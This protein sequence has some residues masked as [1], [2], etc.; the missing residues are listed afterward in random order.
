LSLPEYDRSP[1]DEASIS[2]ARAKLRRDITQWRAYQI[3][4]FPKIRDHIPITDSTRPED[5]NL[6]LP[7]A[8]S[9]ALRIDLGLGDVAAIEYDLREGQAHDALHAVREAIKTFNYNISFKKTNIHGQ[10]A[11]TRAQAFLQS[12]TRDKVSAAD[13]Y[14]RARAALVKLGLSQDDT[15]LQPLYDNELWM[16]NVNEPRKLGETVIPDPWFWT[17]GRP[18]GMSKAQE[19][20]WSQESAYILLITR[21][22]TFICCHSGSG[23]MVP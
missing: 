6:L 19:A 2:K 1:G 16:K 8:F 15:T 14:R 21:S 18:N 7:S 17:V 9:L 12:L 13:K 23:E 20:D 4:H 22:C 3:N 10:R 11:N 5:D